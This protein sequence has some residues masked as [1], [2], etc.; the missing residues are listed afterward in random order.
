MTGECYDGNK[1]FEWI[2]NN[3]P[4][5]GILTVY[6]IGQITNNIKSIINRNINNHLN[7]LKDHYVYFSRIRLL[8]DTSY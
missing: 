6:E 5:G 1:D 2:Q 3:K 8:N 4:Y 7:N